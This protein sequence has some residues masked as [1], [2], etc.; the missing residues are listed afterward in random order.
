MVTPLKPLEAMAMGR[1]LVASDIG[2][3]RE[4]IEHGHTGLLV[5][6][7][8]AEELAAAIARLLDDSALRERLGRQGAAWVRTERTWDRV[9][10][11]YCEVYTAALKKSALSDKEIASFFIN[12]V[13][14]RVHDVL[15]QPF[16]PH[17][18]V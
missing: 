15:R 10:E 9:G 11:R 16:E 12:P 17:T 18:N 8:S 14:A 7:E 5:K 2:G 13:P 1:A 3:H 4:L 6:P